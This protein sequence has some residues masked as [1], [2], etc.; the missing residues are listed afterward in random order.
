MPDLRAPRSP[1]LPGGG[2]GALPALRDGGRC[3]RLG[4]FRAG[5]DAAGSGAVC[6]GALCPGTR[7]PKKL[8]TRYVKE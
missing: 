8:N 5:R 3:A 1:G 2:P 6:R 4:G 7:R